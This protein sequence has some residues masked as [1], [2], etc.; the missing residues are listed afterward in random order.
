MNNPMNTTKSPTNRLLLLVILVLFASCNQ[1]PKKDKPEEMDEKEVERPDNIISLEAA[2]SIYDNYSYYRVPGIQQFEMKERAPE[3]EFEVARYVTF[4][5]ET[6]KQ[7]LA[8]VEQESKK[9]GITPNTLRFY[10]ANYPD[11]KRFDDGKPVIHP[12]QNSI[13]V[14]PTLRD[15]E[16]DWGYYIDEDG[17]AKLIKD[18]AKAYGESQEDNPKSK[19]SFVPNLNTIMFQVGGK[20]LI[21]NHTGSG[22]PPGTDF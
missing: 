14:L 22:P 17:Q 20:S 6:I 9:A 16:N 5:L 11:K 15:G 8:Y 19:A 1:Q 7:Y 21:L 3:K 12:R 10:F 2:K 4:D 13:F 18:W